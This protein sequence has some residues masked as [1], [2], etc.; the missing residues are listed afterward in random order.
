[1]R[2]LFF[3]LL[4]VLLFANAVA[5]Q[6]APN[7]LQAEI[8]TIHESSSISP[9]QKL[10]Q[11]DDIIKRAEK[12]SDS[13]VLFE[14]LVS[15]AEIQI[16][17]EDYASAES[18]YEQAG[19]FARQFFD[20]DIYTRYQIVSLSFITHERY[21]EGDIPVLK[22]LA[23]KAK[24][25]EDKGL[26]S[27][28]YYNLGLFE[29][30]NYNK[31][32][33]VYFMQKAFEMNQ[34]T[35]DIESF[36]NIMTGM[37][38]IALSNSEYEQ[39]LD[40]F[41]QALQAAE[42]QGNRFSESV[43]HYNIAET[44]R[45]NDQ[46]DLAQDA[47]LRTIE[48]SREIGDEIGVDWAMISLADILNNKQQYTQAIGY[49]LDI[50][51]RFMATNT[52]NMA[53][54]CQL[55]LTKAYRELAQL[56]QAQNALNLANELLD[57]VGNDIN[58]VSYANEESALLYAQERYQAAYD[59]LKNSVD[60]RNK[61]HEKEKESEVEKYRISFDTKLTETK[62]AA[63]EAENKLKNIELA[64]QARERK[65]WIALFVLSALL[66]VAFAIWLYAQTKNR[67]KFKQMAL[68]DYLTGAPNRRAILR[69]A[70]KAI[71]D[72]RY[73][74]DNVCLAIADIDHFKQL[75]DHFG[76]ASGDAVLVAFAEACRRVL[77]NQD[78][79]GRYGGEEW[80]FVFKNTDAEHVEHVFK[81]LRAELNNMQ[82]NGIPAEHFISFSMGV[83]NYRPH[84]DKNIDSALERADR[85]LY[86]AK[87]DGRDKLVC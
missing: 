58:L 63:L 9:K 49:Y 16:Y 53:F 41:N 33:A 18:S 50:Y 62:N 59:A 85:R 79:F 43:L 71:H 56:E 46:L 26:A 17:T 77:R 57:K 28:I 30:Y 39:A 84:E 73:T 29:Q 37:G 67:N 32:K 21:L 70:E 3:V 82:I 54:Y 72:A 25:A 80:L 13:R 34:Q 2:V 35:E 22:A 81:R 66:L 19:K 31:A 10:A 52:Y 55:G 11:L 87:S 12:S 61:L 86:Q 20:T 69:F 76:H 14:A 42:Q 36:G 65:L 27:E 5:E 78:H 45:S 38:N 51:P 60:L 44:Y 48:I 75:N 6:L 40:Y 4:S 7:A 74:Q 47:F 1:M 83:A 15:C 23:D 8:K 68:N 24:N 64:E